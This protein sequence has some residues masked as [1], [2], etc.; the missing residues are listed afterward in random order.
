[1]KLGGRHRFLKLFPGNYLAEESI[2]IQQHGV[3][4]EDVVDAHHFLFAQHNV[5][6]VGPALAHY[7]ADTKVRVVIEI[8]AGRDYPIH[9]AGFD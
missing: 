6:N 9:K 8:G 5:G 2:G 7:Q 4:E 1:M 3:V